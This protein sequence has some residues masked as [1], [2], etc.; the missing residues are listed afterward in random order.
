M[1]Q[2]SNPY[3]GFIDPPLI[4]IL[5]GERTLLTMVMATKYCVVG[6]LRNY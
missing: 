3:L 1:W 2:V 5:N 6:I 4:S